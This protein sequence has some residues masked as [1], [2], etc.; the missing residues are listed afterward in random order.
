MVPQ[1]VP[2]GPRK[3]PMSCRGL[4]VPL[5]RNL[6]KPGL[7]G[8]GRV[9]AG[10]GYIQKAGAASPESTQFSYKVNS[11]RKQGLLFTGQ[12][13]PVEKQ[14][15]TIRRLYTLR[16][17]VGK[18]RTVLRASVDSRQA[19]QVFPKAG[20]P[21]A[22]AHRQRTTRRTD[23]PQGARSQQTRSGRVLSK[24]AEPPAAGQEKKIRLSEPV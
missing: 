1:A 2:P 14:G 4:Q 5:E 13:I 8:Q 10:W 19:G 21:Q 17:E 11:S 24:T 16:V 7:M 3:H 18:P 9:S 20:H 12:K 23:C 6:W 22:P 15:E